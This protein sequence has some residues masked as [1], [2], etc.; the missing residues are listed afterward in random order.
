MRRDFFFL[1]SDAFAELPET[2][3]WT[4]AGF[5]ALSDFG[6]EE[7]LIFVFALGEGSIFSSCLRI[8]GRT[9]GRSTLPELRLPTDQIFFFFDFSDVLG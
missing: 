6:L 4:L 7:V 3:E 9:S 2:F 8:H 1:L 5:E